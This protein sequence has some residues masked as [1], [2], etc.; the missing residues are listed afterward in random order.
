MPAAGWVIPALLNRV[1]RL[2]RDTDRRGEF[3]LGPFPFCSRSTRKRVLMSAIRSPMRAT[4][5]HVRRQEFRRPIEPIGVHLA[6]KN[7]H[8]YTEFR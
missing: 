1:D 2:A 7:V 4:H 5:L 3:G 8:F 6:S